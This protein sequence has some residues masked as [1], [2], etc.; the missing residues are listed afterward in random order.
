M[1]KTW[2]IEL[3][4]KSGT[5]PW[6]MAWAA[7][8]PSKKKIGEHLLDFILNSQAYAVYRIVEMAEA[9]RKARRRNL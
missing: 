6:R 3:R 5:G 2:Q 4:V 8:A 1:K 7:R 9:D